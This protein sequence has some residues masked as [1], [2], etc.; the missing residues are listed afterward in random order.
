MFGAVTSSSRKSGVFSGT[1]WHWRESTKELLPCA[2]TGRVV[3]V[4]Y[5]KDSPTKRP[6]TFAS[7]NFSSSSDQTLLFCCRRGTLGIHRRFNM[8]D[9][10]YILYSSRPAK[11]MELFVVFLFCVVQVVLPPAPQRSVPSECKCVLRMWAYD[12]LFVLPVAYRI[13]LSCVDASVAYIPLLL[14]P[15][16]IFFD[17]L[18]CHYFMIERRARNGDQND[19][20]RHRQIVSP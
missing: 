13:Y 2:R 12:L 18:S 11:F 14:F 10:D 8:F 9:V 17:V 16:E 3:T 4:G 5:S 7:T 6:R 19:H 15:L 1:G 20:D